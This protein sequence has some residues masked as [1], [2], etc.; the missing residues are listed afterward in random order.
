M[1]SNM[2]RNDRLI[3]TGIASVIAILYFSNVIGGTLAAVLGVVALVFALTSLVG[4]CPLYTLLG[5]NTCG[6]SRS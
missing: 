2:G 4:F 6:K 5:M 3:R 1:K